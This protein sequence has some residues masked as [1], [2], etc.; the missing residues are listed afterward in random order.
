MLYAVRQVR[1]VFDSVNR[2]DDRAG[3]YVEEDAFACN[4]LSGYAYFAR[5]FEPG[6]ALIHRAVRHVH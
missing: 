1:N 3:A 6:M 2:R 5:R 4:P